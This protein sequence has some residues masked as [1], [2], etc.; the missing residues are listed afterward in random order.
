MKKLVKTC[1]S[2][3]ILLLSKILEAESF[4]DEKTGTIVVENI[5]VSGTLYKNVVIVPEALIS[6][7]TS[8]P[9]DKR[10]R[11]NLPATYDV[12]DGYLTFE[13]IIV[14]DT[15]YSDLIITIKEAL[16]FEATEVIGTA[17]DFSDR[18]SVQLNYLASSDVSK[19][20]IESTLSWAKRVT[21]DW[22]KKDSK[23]WKYFNPIDIW[24]IGNDPEAAAKL[25]PRACKR[26]RRAYSDRYKIDACNPDSGSGLTYTPFDGYA[27]G[28]FSINSNVI[29][30]G[31]HWL[32]V[33]P[34]ESDSVN[35]KIIAHEIFHMYQMA[36]LDTRC[37]TWVSVTGLNEDIRS[38]RETISNILMGKET[39]TLADW[40][41]IMEK[42]SKGK[43]P[44]QNDGTWWGEGGAE[45]MAHWWY[46]Q[47]PE[48]KTLAESDEEREDYMGYQ[49]EQ[50]IKNNLPEF[51]ESGL[52]IYELNYGH[53]RLG[54]D[55]GF[56]FHVYLVKEVGLDVIL[57]G[58]WD[59]VGK[60]GFDNAFLKHFSKTYEEYGL[61]FE[62][63]MNRPDAEIIALLN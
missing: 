32:Y 24:M 61:E 10:V 23:S 28:G 48:A 40:K 51:R 38:D 29:L 26:L 53:G 37:N 6:A 54:Y 1:F 12:T 39:G 36:H 18:P 49:I 16:S 47:Q 2:L 19:Q 5:L 31:Y 41:P 33:G 20:R 3:F 4:Y 44:S 35:G 46:S 56:L 45:Y 25:N 55:M 30:D 60:L 17:K 58:F 11:T 59:E 9:A 8:T 42:D 43:G 14:N 62:S 21:N 27:D 7:G 22:F 52:K 15:S 13:N 57:N 34:S 50:V 63:L